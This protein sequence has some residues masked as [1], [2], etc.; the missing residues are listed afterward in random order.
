MTPDFRRPICFSASLASVAQYWAARKQRSRVASSAA[1]RRRCLTVWRHAT[2]IGHRLAVSGE[3]NMRPLIVGLLAV[4]SALGVEASAPAS[5]APVRLCEQ[6]LYWARLVRRPDGGLHYQYEQ[7]RCLRWAT[8]DIP[9]LVAPFLP[10]AVAPP[11]SPCAGL[12]GIALNPQPLPPRATQTPL[13]RVGL[14]P[15]PLPPRTGGRARRSR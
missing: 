3:A 2:I 12:E 6:W 5:A 13:E 15:Q 1:A 11:P 10:L 4:A 14:N 8:H 9:P 7:Q